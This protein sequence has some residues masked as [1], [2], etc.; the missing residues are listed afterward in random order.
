[1][2]AFHSGAGK[3][4]VLFCNE[5]HAGRPHTQ[6]KRTLL[7]TEG[8]EWAAE[9]T[10]SYLPSYYY[11]CDA[12]FAQTF[13]GELLSYRPSFS[14]YHLPFSFFFFSP[15]EL[16]FFVLSLFQ[17]H[18]LFLPLTLSSTPMVSF[19]TLEVNLV[20]IPVLA[21][22]LLYCVPIAAVSKV[23]E[24]VTCLIESR[25]LNGLTAMSAAA[26][27]SSFSFMFHFLEWHAK[28]EQK[29]KFVDISLQLQ[30]DNK[31]L[32]LERNM[33][34]QLTTCILCLAVKKCAAFLHQR[35]GQASSTPAAATNAATSA[36]AHPK[37]G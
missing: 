9:Q 17:C 26:I 30:H 16:L 1:M 2:P 12:T 37:S 10:T 36:A 11:S 23:A 5:V 14:L 29:E 13:E 8:D 15:A 33:Y 35:D 7:H 28:Y 32:R 18:P 3:T 4:I 20:M 31:R 24:R 21:L 34:I 25:S 27:L 19:L 22:F 6:K